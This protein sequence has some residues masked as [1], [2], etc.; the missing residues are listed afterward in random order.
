MKFIIYK[1]V[2]RITLYVFDD[3]LRSDPNSVFTDSL[4]SRYFIGN[5]NA[6]AQVGNNA[7]TRTQ[8]C[9]SL[10]TYTFKTQP[11]QYI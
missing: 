2:V 6:G 4:N 1:Q 7:K 3:L 11:K 5:L 9:V 8:T 10:D